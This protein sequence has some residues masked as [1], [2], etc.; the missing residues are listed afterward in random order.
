MKEIF[1]HRELIYVKQY[2][3]ILEE[4][5]VP[6]M[7]RNDLAM[8]GLTEIPIP[9]FYPNLCVNEEDAVKAVE[10]LNSHADRMSEGAEEEVACAACGEVNPGN[11]DVCY[12]CQEPMNP[13]ESC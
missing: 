6:T 7:I 3:D 9:E 2:A 11:F 5:G 8:S 1:R 12:S 13:A 10:I 4:A